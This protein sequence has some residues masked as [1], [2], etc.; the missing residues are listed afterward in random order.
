MHT[1]DSPT[2]L[3]INSCHSQDIRPTLSRPPRLHYVNESRLLTFARHFHDSENTSGQVVRALGESSFRYVTCLINRRAR[4]AEVCG[5]GYL[6]VDILRK[7]SP[8]T[9]PANTEE[10]PLRR[11]GGYISYQL[12]MVMAVMGCSR[13]LVYLQL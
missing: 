8:G 6:C 7:K 11:L 1:R 2:P 4:P 5:A 12:L 13:H 3:T 9:F 10:H